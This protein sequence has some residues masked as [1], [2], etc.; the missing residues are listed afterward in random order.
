M[1]LFNWWKKEN[2]KRL[3]ESTEKQEKQVEQENIEAI[4][5]EENEGADVPVSDSKIKFSINNSLRDYG[6]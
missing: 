1:G 5:E 6:E 2:V 3:P 4:S